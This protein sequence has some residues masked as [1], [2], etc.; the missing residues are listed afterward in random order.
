[1][2]IPFYFRFLDYSLKKGLVKVI[3]RL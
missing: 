1:M 2:L 3:N